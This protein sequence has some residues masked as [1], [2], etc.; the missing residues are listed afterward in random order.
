M[1]DDRY[2]F[3]STVYDYALSNLQAKW[4]EASAAYRRAQ[5]DGDAQTAAEAAGSM[6]CLRAEADAL[7]RI[8]AEEVAA[9]AAKASKA[10]P[11]K[12]GLSEEQIEAARDC[13]VDEETYAKGVV[14]LERRKKQKM[15]PKSAGEQ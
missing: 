7:H 9:E 8:A 4:N 5:I 11:N 14:E 15:Y 13:G 10:P 2:D 12:Y 6:A 1:S 3:R